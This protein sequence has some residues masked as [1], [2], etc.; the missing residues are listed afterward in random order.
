MSYRNHVFADLVVWDPDD[1]VAAAADK[2]ARVD[3]RTGVVVD[4]RE[5]IFYRL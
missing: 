1:Q 3:Q 4:M 5:E 2:R